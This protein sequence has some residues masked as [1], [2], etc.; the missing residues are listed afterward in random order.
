MLD[1][2]LFRENPEKIKESEKRRDKDTEKVDRVVRLDNDWREELQRLE[3]LRAKS[4][5]VG[6]EIAEAKKNGEDAQDKIEE[7]SEVKEE[8][9]ELEEEVKRLK[10][11]RDELRYEIGNILH[12]SVP[13]GDGEEDNVELRTWEP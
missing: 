9:A 3:D 6:E 10:E 11:R 7:M 1:I 13:Q 5:R 8:I 12:D 4:N 2:E